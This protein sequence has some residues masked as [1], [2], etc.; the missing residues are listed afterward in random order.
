MFC[1]SGHLGLLSIICHLLLLFNQLHIALNKSYIEVLS[2]VEYT[3]IC[4]F[5][6]AWIWFLHLLSGRLSF[7]FF[8]DDNTLSKPFNV[9]LE[10]FKWTIVSSW[11]VFRFDFYNVCFIISIQ[12]FRDSTQFGCSHCLEL[13]LNRINTFCEILQVIS[14]FS[15]S[16]ATLSSAKLLRLLLDDNSGYFLLPGQF[17]LS[18][19]SGFICLSPLFDHLLEMLLAFLFDYD[20]FGVD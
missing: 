1:F 20:V 2:F 19:A 7:I 15:L 8:F 14:V 18:F 6:F 10:F 4:A 3:R 5:K 12:E 17:F 16:M 9:A 13:Q 11:L